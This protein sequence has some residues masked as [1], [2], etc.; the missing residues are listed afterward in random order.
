LL[1]YGTYIGD[2][3]DRDKLFYD[4]IFAHILPATQGLI[5]VDEA[6]K[7]INTEANAMIDAAQ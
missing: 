6:V 1:P 2:L 5:S 3:S 7:N 4:I